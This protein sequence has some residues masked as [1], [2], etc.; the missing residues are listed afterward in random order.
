MG[1]HSRA[2]GRPCALGHPQHAAGYDLSTHAPPVEARA[3]IKPPPLMEDE[4]IMV[5]CFAKCDSEYKGEKDA[6]RQKLRAQSGFGM[7]GGVDKYSGDSLDAIVARAS[8]AAL[9]DAAAGTTPDGTAGS[10][11]TLKLRADATASGGKCWSVDDAREAM[12]SASSPEA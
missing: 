2:R 11:A 7:E 4:A 12:T 9:A 1:I 3:G 6:F 5:P 10:E 8:A